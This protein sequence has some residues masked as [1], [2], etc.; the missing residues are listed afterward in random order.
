MKQKTSQTLYGYWNEVRG[1]RI[2]PQRFDIEPTRIAAILAETFILESA[3]GKRQKFRIAGS[4]LC[5]LF[6]RELRGGELA[7]LFEDDDRVIVERLMACAEDQAAV[8]LISFEGAA[9]GGR[10][11]RFEM[12]LLPLLH[13][14]TRV[15]RFLGC[16]S[17]T[18]GEGWT[19]DDVCDGQRLIAHEVIWP[20]GRPYAINS[21]MNRQSPFAPE[22]RGARIV[23]VD[24]RRFKVFDG[25]LAEDKSER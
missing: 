13:G 5:E 11:A 7:H 23:S 2:A 24:R 19:G 14:E 25:G 4:R 8:V 17:P 15:N 9:Q 3:P 1:T 12:L 22:P 6:G 18:P 20:D 21:K 10:T 16:I